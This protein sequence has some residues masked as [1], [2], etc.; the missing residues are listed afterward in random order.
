LIPPELMPRPTKRKRLRTRKRGKRELVP[1][2]NEE[3]SA[4]DVLAGI[5]L[6][7]L[8]G[9]TANF[10]EV[11]KYVRR[12]FQ[13]TYWMNVALFTIGVVAFVGAV[14]KGF[15]ADTAAQA[16]PSAVFG[17]LSVASF[18]TAFIFRPV[19]SIERD[20]IYIAWLLSIVNTYWTRIA[21]FEELA[22][23]DRDLLS[24][25]HDLVK[26]LSD[27]AD[28]H[29]ANAEKYPRLS[30]ARRKRAVAKSAPPGADPRAGEP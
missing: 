17:G 23:I 1:P 16:V 30:T 21:Y 28:R 13:T 4:E 11:G 20:S 5:T 19:D 27:L 8:E 18:V 14:V 3:K 12:S 29:A 9:N 6:H 15:S 22:T 7:I 24:A 10:D 2:E 26:Q 25:E